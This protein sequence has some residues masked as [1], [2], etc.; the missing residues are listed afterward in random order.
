M[1]GNPGLRHDLRFTNF[2]HCDSYGAGFALLVRE[3]RQFMCFDMRSQLEFVRIAIVLE[4]TN[5]S[6]GDIEIDD[7]NRRL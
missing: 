4:T 7:R 1:S 2:L 6:A 5:I 3:Q